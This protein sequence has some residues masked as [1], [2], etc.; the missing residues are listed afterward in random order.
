M[1]NIE[2]GK[3]L[4]K[5]GIDKDGKFDATLKNTENSVKQVG[6][7][8]SKTSSKIKSFGASILNAKNILLGFVAGALVR[9]IGELVKSGAELDSLTQSFNRMT[10]NV[11]ESSSEILN[12]LQK[13]SAGTISNRD[14][15]LSANKAIALGVASSTQEFTDL[16]NIARLKAREFGLTT[17]QAFNDIVTGVG[18]GSVMIL[19][20]LGIIIKAEEAQN[21]YAKSL[22]KTAK[23]L[24]VNEQK[25]AL[26]FAV[27]EAGKKA[28]LEAGELQLTY[29][30]RIAQVTTATNNLKDRTGQALLPA[31]ESLLG[32]FGDLNES[33]EQG[34][35]KFNGF[36]LSLYKGLNW[37]IAIG[38]ALS[39]ITKSLFLVGKNAVNMGTIVLGIFADMFRGAHKVGK[40]MGKILTGDFKGAVDEW[41]G[42]AGEIFKIT[43]A[44]VNKFADESAKSVQGISDTWDS[45]GESAIKAVDGHGFQKAVDLN[46]KALSDYKN[47]IEDTTGSTDES[48]KT[49]EEWTEAIKKAKEEAIKTAETLSSEL[50]KSFDDFTKGVGDNLAETS[51]GLADIVIQAEKRRQEIKDAL[52]E[53]G[54]DKSAL[55]EELAGVEEVLKAR[56]N[57]EK[58][59]ADKLLEIRSKLEAA[60]VDPDSVGLTNGESSLEA[61]IAE[62]KRVAS[63]DEFTRFKE[64]QFK[65]LDILTTDFITENELYTSK[66]NHQKELEAGFTKFMQL[67]LSKRQQAIQSFKMGDYSS[68]AQITSGANPGTST[69]TNKTVNA[70]VNIA[71]TAK[72]MNPEELSA[73]LGFELNKHI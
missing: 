11:G 39:L 61:D 28:V 45:M 4:Y 49:T 60:G 33:V 48:K 35:E 27:L 20:N 17:T 24:T 55:R 68:P 73:I 40:T 51:Q 53:D 43:T 3:L 13:T 23:E 67:E 10:A 56:E 18:R 9:G 29:A 21:I 50:K 70:N 30:D 1:A 34:D 64:Q 44:A 31:M 5:I 66:I 69:T 16:M 32:V 8:M 58:E 72:E 22:G 46:A 36:S 54:A 38:K 15:M 6:L 47:N 57:F 12:A 52:K 42:G 14:L 71:G 65:K 19:D 2:I 7:E 37:V 62:K 63:L 25:E 26:K 41:K 59:H